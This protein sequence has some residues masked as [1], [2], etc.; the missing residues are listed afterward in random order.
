MN[1]ETMSRYTKRAY[2]MLCREKRRKN[3]FSK[4]LKK[5]FLCVCVNPMVG[6]ENFTKIKALFYLPISKKVKIHKTE[7][8]AQNHPNDKE[9]VHKF[10]FNV[11]SNGKV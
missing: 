1:V 8:R 3:S 10:F 7:K 9:W 5:K 4:G 11:I 2:F 6:S